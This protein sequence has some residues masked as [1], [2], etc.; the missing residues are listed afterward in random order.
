MRTNSAESRHQT[1]LIGA[2]FRPPDRRYDEAARGPHH[3][4]N[5]PSLFAVCRRSDSSTPYR[6]QQLDVVVSYCTLAPIASTRD[7]A[8]AIDVDVDLTRLGKAVGKLSERRAPAR[9]G[10]VGLVVWA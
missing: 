10:A 6:A 8:E 3:R 5:A 2:T 1:E 4:P 7:V 9:D